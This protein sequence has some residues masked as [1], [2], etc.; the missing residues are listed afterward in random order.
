MATA[1]WKFVTSEVAD[2]YLS[3]KVLIRPLSYY[4]ESGGGLVTRPRRAQ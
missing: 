2:F 4:R 1:V 3:G